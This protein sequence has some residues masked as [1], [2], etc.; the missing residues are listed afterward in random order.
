VLAAYAAFAA[1]GFAAYAFSVL[2]LID[3]LRSQG[4]GRAGLIAAELGVHTLVT[5]G[6]VLGRVF[7][8]NSWDLLT[9]PDAVIDAVRV[10]QT[11]RGMAVLIFFIAALVFGTLLVRLA[12]AAIRR[13][14]R[15]YSR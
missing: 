10:P 6:V 8:F 14:H 7:R 2:R 11:Q 1:I 5:V 9:R 15:P 3:Y 13:T 4:L 12:V